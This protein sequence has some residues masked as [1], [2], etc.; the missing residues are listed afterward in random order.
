MC[1]HFERIHQVVPSC[2]QTNGVSVCFF[3]KA[4]RRPAECLE[5]AAG[6]MCTICLQPRTRC[7]MHDELSA[8][9]STI[10]NARDAVRFARGCALTRAIALFTS[11]SMKYEAMKIVTSIAVFGSVSQ[12]IVVLS[13]QPSR[14][15]LLLLPR[16]SRRAGSTSKGAQ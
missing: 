3:A 2:K 13:A 5:G 8:D 12:Y 4:T 14:Q 9:L 16:R 11:N 10:V 1:M 6:S 7:A 15:R